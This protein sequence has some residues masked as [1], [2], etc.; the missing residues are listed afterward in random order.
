MKKLLAAMAVAVLVA[1]CGQGYS[2]GERIGTIS[3]FSRKG[4]IF[5]SWEGEMVLG[6]VIETEKGVTANIFR[7]SVVDPAVVDKIKAINAKGSRARL[8]YTQWI[9]SGPSMGTSYEVVDAI[10]LEK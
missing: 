7:F 8:V 4:L 10:E 1:A 3:K 9:V 2:E 5:K 6:G